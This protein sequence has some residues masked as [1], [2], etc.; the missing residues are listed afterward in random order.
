[1]REIK[2]ALFV[3]NCFIMI[4]PGRF[5]SVVLAFSSG[6]RLRLNPRISKPS[7]EKFPRYFSTSIILKSSDKTAQDASSATKSDFQYRRDALHDALRRI[8][9]DPEVLSKANLKN[10]QDP[11]LGYDSEIG[12]PAIR[13]YRSFLYPKKADEFSAGDDDAYA[14][15]RLLSAADRCARQIDF[16]RR[17]HLSHETD[18]VRHTDTEDFVSD[19]ERKDLSEPSR[20]GAFPLILVLDNVRSAFNVGSIFRTADACGCQ[21]VITV[22]K[23]RKN[24]AQYLV[25]YLL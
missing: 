18:W 24:E 1:M 25:Y 15:S 16:L 8:H 6:D 11:T 13:T 23:E 2:L 22:S 19:S 17:R 12:K 7:I 14:Q 20:K 9:L 10:M 5:R 3:L 4:L 21:Q